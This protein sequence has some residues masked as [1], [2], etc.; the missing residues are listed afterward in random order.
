MCGNVLRC[1]ATLMWYEN[2]CDLGDKI[3]WIA[4]TAFL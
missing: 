1:T 3:T 4:N 2:I